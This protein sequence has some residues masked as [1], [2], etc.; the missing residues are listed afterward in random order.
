MR[1][2][3][4]KGGSNIS[5]GD[6]HSDEGIHISSFLDDSDE[7]A[8]RQSSK[9]HYQRYINDKAACAQHNLNYDKWYHGCENPVHFYRSRIKYQCCDHT[10]LI[11]IT[12]KYL[13]SI[14]MRFTK[15]PKSLTI[16][17]HLDQIHTMVDLKKKIA[18]KLTHLMRKLY[19][20]M[21]YTGFTWD[22]VLLYHWKNIESSG[23]EIHSLSDY[24]PISHLSL[25]YNNTFYVKLVTASHT[26]SNSRLIRTRD[27]T[28]QELY[29]DEGPIDKYISIYL[30]CYNHSRQVDKYVI[31]NLS[32]GDT[33]GMLNYIIEKML[34]IRDLF[35]RHKG[36]LW[37]GK[38]YIKSNATNMT[39]YD[40]NIRN[41]DTLRLDFDDRDPSFRH[42][43]RGYMARG[44]LS[45]SEFEDL[46][47]D[48]WLH[49]GAKQSDH[50]PVR[51]YT[52]LK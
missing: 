8:L 25:R 2:F 15:F 11:P 51:W 35:N 13:T 46:T 19:P 28:R 47:D 29:T 42:I 20:D 5:S 10:H 32:P 4:H 26:D 7:D 14:T 12:I 36:Y 39:L 48:K 37:F 50:P 44:K 16:Y 52:V 34:D 45:P 18:R 3:D 24:F 49:T 22:Q 43:L 38:Q 41:G 30:E 40:Y 31:H 9:T 1:Y 27:A 21:P 23:L 17:V 33:I 6:L